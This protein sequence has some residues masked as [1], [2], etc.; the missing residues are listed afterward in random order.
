[1]TN[2]SALAIQVLLVVFIVM[3]ALVLVERFAERSRKRLYIKYEFC[4]IS[5]AHPVDDIEHAQRISNCLDMHSMA[6]VRVVTGAG[7]VTHH[8]NHNGHIVRVDE[9]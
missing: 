1:M 8:R 4:G 6:D 5:C 2:S 9:V 3:L 7:K